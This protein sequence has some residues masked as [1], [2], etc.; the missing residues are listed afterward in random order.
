MGNNVGNAASRL[1]SRQRA[2]ERRILHR[3][4]RA[5][6]IATDIALKHAI[7]FSHHGSATAFGA[8]SGNRLHHANRE[9][10]RDRQLFRIKIP[11]VAIVKATHGNALG[12]INRRATTDG[13]NK[14]NPIGAYHFDTL[15]NKRIARIRL[16]ATE[17]HMGNSS[18]IERC[19]HAVNQTRTHRRAPTVMN[20]H[21]GAAILF[22]EFTAFIFAVLAEYEFRGA[23]EVEI[24]HVPS[25]LKQSIIIILK[26]SVRKQ[27]SKIIFVHG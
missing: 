13:Q 26:N 4:L 5:N 17:F 6:H 3:K 23:V 27:D 19:L 14:V 2:K 16:H 8:R 9:R 18:S 10:L 12:A 1:I 20:Q 24:I 15:V 21:L 25:F 22:N 7:F 11:E